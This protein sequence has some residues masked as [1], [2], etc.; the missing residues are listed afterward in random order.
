MMP[1]FV[2]ARGNALPELA[3]VLA[4][5][6]SPHPPFSIFRYNGR[7]PLIADREVERLRTAERKVV[8][9]A[10]QRVFSPGT[11]VHIPEGAF[12]GLSGIVEDG[13]GKSTMVCFGGN[14]SFNIATFLLQPD[15][16]STATA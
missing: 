15:G 11:R 1:S 7:I 16:I 12:A 3:D 10:K 6:V 5:P 14:V 2:F 9:K 13:N 4:L 8:P